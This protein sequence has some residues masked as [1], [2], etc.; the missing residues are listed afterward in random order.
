MKKEPVLF[1]L[2]DSNK[3]ILPAHRRQIAARI[4]NKENNILLH[5]NSAKKRINKKAVLQNRNLGTV[6]F[7]RSRTATGTVILRTLVEP[8]P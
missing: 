6:T 7:Y 4:L 8:E 1:Y 5:H 2:S 3:G